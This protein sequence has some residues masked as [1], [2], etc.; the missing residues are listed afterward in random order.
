MHGAKEARGTPEVQQQMHTGHA[1][2]R[3]TETGTKDRRRNT[4][5]SLPH[6]MQEAHL[7]NPNTLQA[8]SRTNAEGTTLTHT[9]KK[10]LRDVPGGPMAEALYFPRGGT[11]STL[12]GE[13]RYHMTYSQK[14]EEQKI[15]K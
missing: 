2:G 11:G 12:V 4:A 1:G 3:R 8:P 13:L 14:T 6:A 15:N 5:N 10:L 7:H 9:V